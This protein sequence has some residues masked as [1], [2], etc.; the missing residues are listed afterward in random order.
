MN[1]RRLPWLLVTMFA[2]GL[3]RWWVPPTNGTS[4][5]LAEPSQHAVERLRLQ[6][7]AP[8]SLPPGESPP[9]NVHLE[10]QPLEAMA[11]NQIVVTEARSNAFAV[12]PSAHAVA[13]MAAKPAPMPVAPV[14]LPPSPPPTALISQPAAPQVQVIGTWDDPSAPGVFV[15]TTNGTRLVRPG[16]VLDDV[17]RVSSIDAGQILLSH[18]SVAGEWRI[19]IPRGRAN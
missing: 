4:D 12:R 14:P 9:P 19:Q 5:S 3:L 8:G 7:A 18:A 6:V 13:P 16:D 17:Y 10:R 15:Q 2:L 11:A 1:Q